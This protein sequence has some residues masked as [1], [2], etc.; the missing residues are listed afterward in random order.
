VP[1]GKQYIATYLKYSR[2]SFGLLPVCNYG[3]S[4]QRQIPKY[5]HPPLKLTGN[6]KEL[7]ALKRS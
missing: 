2:Q 6:F 5:T 1:H 7:S 4:Y 3:G